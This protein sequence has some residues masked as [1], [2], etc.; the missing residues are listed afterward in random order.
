MLQVFCHEFDHLN[1]ITFDSWRV[2]QGKMHVLNPQ[3]N[4]NLAQVII[5]IYIYIDYRT[6]HSKNSKHDGGTRTELI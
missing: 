3:D 4:P 1:G 5:Y 6:L 2:S